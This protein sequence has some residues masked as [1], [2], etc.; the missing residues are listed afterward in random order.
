MVYI[1]SYISLWYIYILY[2]S[3]KVCFPTFNPFL[4]VTLSCN[5]WEVPRKP[6]F[7]YAES[8]HCFDPRGRV[9]AGTIRGSCSDQQ[10]EH[11]VQR[12]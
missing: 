3:S 9:A 1:Y 11:A 6:V 5:I 7:C 2:F 8:Q 4:V 10:W 12:D